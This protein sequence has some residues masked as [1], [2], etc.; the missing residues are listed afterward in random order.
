METIENLEL[1]DT[2]NVIY[3]NNLFNFCE[4]LTSVNVSNFDTSKVEDM[5]Y[6][7]AQCSSLSS[8]NVSTWNTGNVEDMYIMFSGCS[9]LKVLDISNWNTKNVEN[10][11]GIF[12]DCDL[13]QQ[14]TVGVNFELIG[15]YATFPV[16][17]EDYIAGTDGKWHNSAGDTFEANAIPTNKA[18]TYYAIPQ[19]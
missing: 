9:S 13:L 5:S 4:K 16:P 2:S 15:E 14:I 19:I 18:D 8:I 11:W 6:M 7:F 12:T 10:M 3:M 17:N 1:L